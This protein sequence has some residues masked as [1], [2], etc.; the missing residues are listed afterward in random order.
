MEIFERFAWYGFF[1]VSSLYLTTPIAQGGLGFTEQQRGTLQGVVP[2]FLYLLPVITGALGDRYGYRRMFI[3]SFLIMSPSYFLLGQ[4][5]SFAGFFV[6]FLFVAIGAATFK[7]LVVGTV[8]RSTDDTNRGLGF[9]IF[10]TMVNLGGFMGPIIAGTVRNISWNLVFVMASVWIAFNLIPVIFLYRDPPVKG[11]DEDRSGGFGR[12]LLD[13]QEVLG[14]A[15]FALLVVPLLLLLMVGG[16]G[17]LRWSTVGWSIAGWIVVNLLWNLAASDRPSSPWYR[18]RTRIGNAPFVTYLLIMAG[19]WTVYN[20]VFNTLPIY[21]RDHIETA[22]IVSVANRISPS[23][24]MT[25]AE[26]NE[27]ALAEQI[28]DLRREHAG[29]IDAAA[30]AAIARELVHHKVRV[31]AD[32]VASGLGALD[33]VSEEGAADL[34][35]RW[36]DEYRQVNPEYLMSLNFGSILL[37]QILVSFL[38][39]RRRVF[40][41]LVG[42]TIL[43]GVGY[44]TASWAYGLAMGGFAIVGAIVVF[45]FGEMLASPKSQDYVAGVMPKSK[46]AMFM[47]YYFVS[48]ALGFLFGG[49]LSGWSYDLFSTKLD[50]PHLMWV[51]Y[52]AMAGATAAALLVFNRWVAP[53]LEAAG[54]GDPLPAS[55][56]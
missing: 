6:V 24:A 7:P 52:A 12:L 13:V 9:G 37:F 4:A 55:N 48:M 36:A 41:V 40:Y 14:N 56:Q 11:A 44:L 22:D 21:I 26:V 28:Q 27:G 51:L 39:E 18:K 53:K 31:P 29:G 16:G 43:V 54:T 17:W 50:L 38:V 23:L 32:T 3:L 2:F 35:R 8:S 45:S 10:Y 5:R 25:L 1:T 47:G 49:I 34:A 46:A 30:G 19:F 20:Q 33:A 15:R 42:G